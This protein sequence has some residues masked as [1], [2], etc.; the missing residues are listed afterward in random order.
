MPLAR[1]LKLQERPSEAMA[2]FAV[3]MGSEV[4]TGKWEV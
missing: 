3:E 4:A 2:S 1:C